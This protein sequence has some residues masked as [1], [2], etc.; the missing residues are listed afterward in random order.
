M[1][2]SKNILPNEK[3]PE[4]IK[5]LN[6]GISLLIQNSAFHFSLIEEKI[7]KYLP[8]VI[9]QSSQQKNFSNFN[10]PWTFDV[11]IF[12][13]KLILM[14][15]NK[16]IMPN[17]QL[18]YFPFFKITPMPILPHLKKGLHCPWPIKRENHFLINFIKLLN[19]YSIQNSQFLNIQIV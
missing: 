14:A 12:N 13:Q 15:K 5:K 3:F 6:K 8:E 1:K 7:F 10:L 18:E 4:P 9:F 11:S 16:S 2:N 19:K 17:P